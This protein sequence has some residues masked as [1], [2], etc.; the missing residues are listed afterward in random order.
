M[1]TL[2][3][4][5]Q[6]IRASLLDH[7]KVQTIRPAWN[8][9]REEK[10]ARFQLGE[11]VKIYWNQKKNPNNFIGVVEITDIFK[12]ELWIGN[13][14]PLVTGYRLRDTYDLAK[15]D[16]FPAGSNGKYRLFYE[17]FMGHYDLSGAK[18]FWVYRWIWLE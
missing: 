17:F 16:G 18:P 11:K 5:V 10:P 3:F 7:M 12:I 6:G 13:D 15:K 14:A 2:N 1:K 8:Y 9:K 4:T